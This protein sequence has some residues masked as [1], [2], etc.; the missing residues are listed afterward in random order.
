MIVPMRKILVVARS[1]DRARLL[2]SLCELG[3]V[4]V[5]PVNPERATVEETIARRIQAT[6]RALQVLSNVAP[7]GKVPDMAPVDAALEILDIQRRAAEGRH[8]LA[9][10]Y[11]QLQQIAVW[12]DMRLEDLDALAEAGVNVHFYSMPSKV[13]AAADAQCV[14]VVAD[15]PNR[16]SLVALAGRTDQVKV[17]P[18]AKAVPAPSRD[19]PSIRTEAAEIEASLKR[20][21]RRLSELANLATAMKTEL[22]RL[23]QE[24]EYAAALGGAQSD[25]H[26][27]A[28]Q[29]WTTADAAP[30]IGAQ[31][32][33]R[34]IPVALEILEPA[35]DEQPPTLIRSPA[36]ARPIESLFQML[37]TVPG[38]REYDVSVPFLIALPLFT[39]VLISDAGYGG[40]LLLGL[41]LGYGPASKAI[42]PRFV[43]LLMLVG[44][45]AMI[46]GAVTSAYFG[47]AP[48]EPLISIDLSEKSRIWMMRLSFTVG[49]IHLSLAQAWQA[50]RL[51]PDLRFLNKV[52]WA[53]FVWGMY[54]VVNMFVLKTPM[55]WGTVWP[56]LLLTGGVLAVV[57]AS[58]NR[59]PAKMLGMGLAEFPLS[60]LSA[61]SDVISYVRLMAVGLASSVLA[62]SFNEM[63][64]SAAWPLAV[65][66]LV[67]GHGL[68]MG[69]GLIA[70]FA[71][72]VRLNMLEFCNNLG[73]KWTGY[74]YTP[75]TRRLTPEHTT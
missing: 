9:G 29:G 56:Y 73:M 32:A 33:A 50:V 10:L 21:Q 75:F 65:L 60:M 4:H 16:Q 57:F 61:F 25:E 22:L 23:Q 58:P 3:V 31:L 18:E 19:A 35:S 55:H 41:A 11:H 38:Y 26:L 43:H 14:S 2:D 34:Q 63:A 39:A 28:M 48:Y 44:A 72:G 70:M 15:F 59:N 17:P 12:G 69:L 52:G 7:G 36:W 24:A 71:H 8:R 20:D 62:T 53:L 67:F 6:Q 1:Q 5:V 37:G 47:F 49:A 54:G 45:V 64:L 27:F 74:P 42:G 66:I 40:L 30:S 68:N 51:Y 46:W 13:V